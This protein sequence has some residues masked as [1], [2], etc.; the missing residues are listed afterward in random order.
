VLENFL[1]NYQGCLI[2]V[3]HDRYFM[4][5]MVDHLLV[6]EGEGVVKEY[7][8]NYTDYRNQLE[9]DKLNQRNPNNEVKTPV[10]P[11]KADDNKTTNKTKLS[12]KEQQELNQIELELATLEKEKNKLI[13]MLSSGLSNEQLLNTS[14]QIESIETQIESITL[15]W[16]ELEDKKG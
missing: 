3:S 16:L 2:I 11:P 14:K 9:E 7:P 10:A 4:D 13:E 15:R 6:F 5:Q 1:T 12:Y 8:G